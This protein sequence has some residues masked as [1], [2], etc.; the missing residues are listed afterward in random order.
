MQLKIN[1]FFVRS[2]AWHRVHQAEGNILMLIYDGFGVPP[3]IGSTLFTFPLFFFILQSS[4]LFYAYA[5]CGE[6]VRRLRNLFEGQNY[7]PIY[8]LP[9][10][11]SH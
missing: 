4:C 11:K 8:C 5:I 1:I 7:F 3:V 6:A 10:T 9:E 2:V